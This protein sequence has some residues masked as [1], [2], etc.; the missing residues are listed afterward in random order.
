[1]AWGY[2][3]RRRTGHR[4]VAAVSLTA[5]ANIAVSRLPPRAYVPAS[6]GAA[7][8]LTWLGRRMGASW[9][10][11]G[12]DPGRLRSGV[13][14]GLGATVPIAGAIALGVAI[15]SSRRLFA[16]ERASSAG[17][18]EVRYHTLYRIP[19]GTALAEEVLFRGALLGIFE[20]GRSRRVADALTGVLFGLWHI[21]PTLD[22]LRTGPV[23]KAVGEDRLS[24]A[25]AVGGVVLITMAAGYVLAWLRDRSGSLAAP[26][27]AHTALNGLAF[28]AAR[29]A[30]RH[31]AA[32]ATPWP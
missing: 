28:L 4:E 17:R 5:V 32:T 12:M 31:T 26:V 13:R 23:S 8:A 6:L 1:M 29:A 25:T 19:L 18:R 3:M 27:I 22:R 2:R 21:V 7:A 11:M 10:D 16:D 30:S 24:K 15:P 14:W 20:R 9:A